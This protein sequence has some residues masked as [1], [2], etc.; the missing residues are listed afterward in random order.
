MKLARE[1]IFETTLT[2]L[3][4]IVALLHE[5]QSKKFDIYIYIY[6]FLSMSHQS[7]CESVDWWRVRSP[8]A[9][10]Q[11]ALR[12]LIPHDLATTTL[13]TTKQ[14]LRV[15]FQLRP[16]GFMQTKTLQEPPSLSRGHY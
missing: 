2:L 9:L 12:C 16:T 15:G 11:T 3:V 8:A 5:S 1:Q 6:L 7:S 13:S 10:S 4:S 14:M